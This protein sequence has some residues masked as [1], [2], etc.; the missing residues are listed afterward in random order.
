MPT[1]SQKYPFL[2]RE[3]MNPTLPI[4]FSLN[5]NFEAVSDSS[6][7]Q[8]KEAYDLRAKYLDLDK[9]SLVIKSE[10]V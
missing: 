10:S 9:R 6:E 7:K 2:G 1:S 5:E 3:A 4:H 8:L